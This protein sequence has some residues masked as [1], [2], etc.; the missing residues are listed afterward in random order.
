MFI[1]LILLILLISFR[2]NTYHT[3]KEGVKFGSSYG[4]NKGCGS[5]TNIKGCSGDTSCIWRKT[6]C[7]TKS[8]GDF[9]KTK[10][11]STCIWKNEKC[12]DKNCRDHQ[13]ENQ[14]KLYTNR[15]CVWDK[16]GKTCGYKP[17]PA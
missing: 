1:L 12:V 7:L 16:N 8:C 2:E 3:I 15:N 10:C 17:K 13:N 9:G 6:K 4:R 11:H 5:H 14:C